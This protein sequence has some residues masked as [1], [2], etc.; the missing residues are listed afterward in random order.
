MFLECL[1]QCPENDDPLLSQCIIL[2]NSHLDLLLLNAVPHV[3]D[4]LP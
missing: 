1:S 2:E 3:Y 4:A